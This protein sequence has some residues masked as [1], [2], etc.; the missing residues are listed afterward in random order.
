[1]M[2]EELYREILRANGLGATEALAGWT[3]DEAPEPGK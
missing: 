1:M 2:L 3:E